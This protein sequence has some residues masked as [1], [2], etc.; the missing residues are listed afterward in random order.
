MGRRLKHAINP[1]NT[2]LNPICHFLALLEAHPILHVSRIRVKGYQCM[3]TDYKGH[4]RT[5]ALK[6]APRN[7]VV[8]WN[9]VS[10][11]MVPRL[12]GNVPPLA[13]GKAGDL[14]SEGRV[15]GKRTVLSK[16]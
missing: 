8:T 3:F 10:V 15:G 2:K 4:M 13:Q 12:A 14:H 5:E 9:T 7:P 11:L 6:V 1:L 16:P